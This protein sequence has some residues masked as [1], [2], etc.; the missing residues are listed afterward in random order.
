MNSRIRRW[1]RRAVFP[2]A[3]FAAALT[4]CSNHSDSAQTPAPAPAPAPAPGVVN[5]TAAVGAALA[6][7]DVSVID[8]TRA[9]VC[10]ES[11]IVTSG[12]GTFTCTV[13]AGKT[14][15]FVVVVTDPAGAYPALVS[16]V[17]AAP[18]AGSSLVVNATPLTTAIVAQA[19][20]DG[21]ALSLAADPSLVDPNALAAVKTNVLAQIAPVLSAVGTPANYDPFS[22][23]I[24]AATATQA[25][26]TSDQLIELLRF[27]TVDGVTQVSTI[28]NP[29]GAVPVAGTT[30]TT[31]PVLP[32][33]SATALSLSDAMRLLANEFARC[34]ALPV[35]SRVLAEDTGTPASQGGPSVTS[36]AP[37]CQGIAHPDYLNNG[38]RLGQ[39]YYGLLNDARMVG[40]K[41]NP[42]EI[43]LF[44]DDATAADNDRAVLNIRYVDANGVAGNLIEVASK[45]PGSATATHA[46][47][48]WVYGTQQP[49]DTGVLPFVRRNEQF[50]PSPGTAPF[51]NAGASRFES[52]IVL[53]VNKDGPGST[54]LRA[55][56]VTGPGLPPAGIVLTRP[57][58]AI[59]TDQNWLNIRRKDGL[60]DPAAAT[61][62]ADVGNIF[63]LQRTQGVTGTA[64]TTVRPNPNAGNPDN[65]SFPAWA[66]PLDYNAPVGSTT[67][68]DFAQLKAN[69]AYQFEIFYDG[70]LTP[71]HTF[72]RRMVAPVI[73]ATRAVNLQWIDLT[74]ATLRYLDPADAL[75]AEQ[76]TIKLAWTAN[77]YAETVNNA[78]VYTFGG[79]LAVEDA[80]VPVARGATSAVAGAPGPNFRALTDD[81]TSWRTIQL[82]YRMLDGSYKDTTSRFN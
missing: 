36:L 64:A 16:V 37:E 15:P 49:V 9:N 60:T 44:L 20:P 41:F 75:A 3:L 17:G 72:T 61:F 76:A 54:G 43:M 22:S 14:A 5:G 29:D 45:L 51:A 53:F 35:A 78:G 58:P 59:V 24:V 63:R 81:G 32:A 62:A 52:G 77:P 27:S 7:A 80:I 66:H 31:P 65:V 57:D 46:T 50:A 13:L 34:F 68:V 56:R 67:Y 38:F 6:N 4:G 55:A 30:T 47:D 71:R 19:A 12:T 11:D 26:N 10:V 33:P 25:G 40:A 48:W 28:D 2:A 42:P 79:G 1:A 70:E 73:P 23:Q 39:R 74:P 69:S 18:A 21:N 8:R 82:R